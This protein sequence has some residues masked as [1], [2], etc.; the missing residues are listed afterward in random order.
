M[1]K[2]F[3]HKD[4]KDFAGKYYVQRDGRVFAKGKEV[5]YYRKN[6]GGKF[7]R[8]F[9]IGKSTTITV[10]KIVMLTY[11]PAG[12]KKDKIVLHLDGNT[13]NDSIKNL[14]FGTRQEQ[15]FIHVLNPKNWERISKMGK[16]YGHI[17]GK[18]IAH[19]GKQNLAK[20]KAENK[21]GHPQEIIDRIHSLFEKG[22]TPS[23][24]ATKLNISRSSVYNHI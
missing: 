8:L 21:P 20:W 13:M 5:R 17:N 4:Y 24:I 6:A 22:T 12:Y 23:E 16:K 15:S 11:K 1:K 7:I 14:R 9:N 10:A 18:K 3:D 2:V 19:I